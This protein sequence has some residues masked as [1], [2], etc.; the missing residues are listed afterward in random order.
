M[1]AI[2]TL[3]GANKSELA[4]K[5]STSLTSGL[6]KN[7]GTVDETDYQKHMQFKSMPTASA[8]NVGA[9]VQ[10]SGITTAHFTNGYFY[11]CTEHSGSYSWTAVSVQQG[12]GGGGGSYTAGDGIDIDNDM[13][14]ID[15][16]PAEDM[17]EVIGSLP[18]GG[19][20]VLIQNAFNR[21]DLY[22]TDERMI[23]QWTDGKPLY[24]KSIQITLTGSSNWE[25]TNHN[26]SNMDECIESHGWVEVS[27]EFLNIPH[28]EHQ[29]TNTLCVTV[30]A[31]KIYVLAVGRTGTAYAT[32]KY[33]KTT[34]SAIAIGTENEYSTT[35]KIVGT[36]IDGKP[37]YQKTIDCGALPNNTTKNVAHGIAHLG[38]VCNFFGFSK[39]QY[40][41]ETIKIPN[42]ATE[43]T[44]G[45]SID[46]TN[47]I[48]VTNANY[49]NYTESY[50]TIQYTKTT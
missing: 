42:P 1:S 7:D 32:V 40:T 49:S 21:A 45:I 43:N 50:L 24:Q 9:I 30:D 37:L 18:S 39:H 47:I 11:K 19:Q 12:G 8:D 5:V 26:I 46:D 6:L 20:V 48:I 4:D 16:M 29:A 23:G 35:E 41:N 27:N 44:C 34:D 22:S 15:P 14:S 31:S 38:T 10:Y 28:V 13:I 2:N 33:T 17:D 36:W 3:A 25:G